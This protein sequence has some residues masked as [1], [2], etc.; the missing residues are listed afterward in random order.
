MPVISVHNP[1]GTAEYMVT[2]WPALASA[3]VSI[4]IAPETAARREIELWGL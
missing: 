1:V 4:T 2:E 3:S